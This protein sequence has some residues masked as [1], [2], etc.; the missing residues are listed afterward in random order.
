MRAQQEY[1]D[2][3]EAQEQLIGC[4]VWKTHEEGEG[5]TRTDRR[6]P[7]GQVVVITLQEQ[8]AAPEIRVLQTCSTWQHTY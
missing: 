8:Y 6:H 7:E 1:P 2:E 4:Y 3:I 5:V